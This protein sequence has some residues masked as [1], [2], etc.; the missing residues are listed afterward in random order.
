MRT[1]D[2]PDTR[3]PFQFCPGTN[4]ADDNLI[5]SY[6]AILRHVSYSS[7]VHKGHTVSF[8]GR[9]ND[10]RKT[11]THHTNQSRKGTNASIVLLVTLRR[12]D[13]LPE[14]ASNNRQR[15]VPFSA[16]IEK[17]LPR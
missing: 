12:A 11:I 3:C 5:K 13:G 14:G 17:V 4:S 2:R 10:V 9:V 8:L 6:K 16:S 15:F 1:S 7:K